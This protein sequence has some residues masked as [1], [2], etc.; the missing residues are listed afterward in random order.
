MIDEDFRIWLIECNTNPYFGIPNKFIA[1]LLPR[2]ISEMF[3][4][5]LDPVYPPKRKYVLPEKN[6]ELIYTPTNNTRRP[7]DTPLYPIRE[8]EKQAPASRTGVPSRSRKSRG[9]YKRNHS[10]APSKNLSVPK[11]SSEPRKKTTS[12]VRKHSSYKSNT[13]ELERA[14]LSSGGKTK[15]PA[16][17]KTGF[18]LDLG[19]RANSGEKR[20]T[21]TPR[22]TV[23]KKGHLQLSVSVLTDELLTGKATGEYKTKNFQMVMSRIFTK[24]SS[25]AVLLNKTALELKE[26]KNDYYNT[27][28]PAIIENENPAAEVDDHMDLKRIKTEIVDPVCESLEKLAKSKYIVKINEHEGGNMFGKF[29][30][31]IKAIMDDQA[32]NWLEEDDRKEQRSYKVNL[33]KSMLEI[34]SCILKNDKIKNNYTDDEAIDSLIDIFLWAEKYKDQPDPFKKIYELIVQLL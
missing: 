27:S 29:L 11:K 7:F 18:K 30:K 9:K 33:I 13:K 32:T 4:I 3:E 25:C 2:M 10:M 20:Q 28:L 21:I 12:S 34:V 19:S 26:P 6:F 31:D 5:V 1:D 23:P 14:Y 16:L 15:S 24:L 22:N 17:K 8:P